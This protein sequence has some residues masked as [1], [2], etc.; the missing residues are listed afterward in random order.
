M[1]VRRG[2]RAMHGDVGGLRTAG[3]TAVIRGQGPR[4]GGPDHESQARAVVGIRPGL[5]C[6]ARGRSSSRKSNLT[7]MAGADLVAVLDLR[8]GEG[9]VAVRAPVDRLVA[10]ID[11]ALVQIQSS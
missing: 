7:K 6:R 3:M 8:L 9:R 5:E 11:H 2:R 10:A 1:S 4:G